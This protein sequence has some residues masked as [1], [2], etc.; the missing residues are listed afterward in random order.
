M[1]AKEIVLIGAL[2]FA[3]FIVSEFIIEH[4]V[5]DNPF[6]RFLARLIL[7]AQFY[8]VLY[9]L[10]TMWDTQKRLRWMEVLWSRERRLRLKN[11]LARAI[12]KAGHA[13]KGT[14]GRNKTW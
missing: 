10:F 2:F 12:P 3:G 7:Q 1:K 14:N 9:L 4:M 13:R 6:Q 5:F 8:L 11:R